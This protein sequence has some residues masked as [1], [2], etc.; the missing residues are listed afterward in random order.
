MRL[1]YCK[2]LDINFKATPTTK[3]LNLVVA[4]KN[5]TCVCGLVV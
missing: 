2:K 3:I 5:I 1:K 4:L